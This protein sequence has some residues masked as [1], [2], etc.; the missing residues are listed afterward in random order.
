MEASITDHKFITSGLLIAAALLIR[1]FV[2]YHLNKQHFRDDDNS[3]RWINSAKNATNLII[4]MGL[5]F[6]WITELRFVALSIAT[7][8]VA[9][10]IATREFIQCFL[11][12]IYQASTRS[13]IVGDWIQLGNQCG[14]VVS[15]DWLSTRLLEIDIETCSYQTT[16]KTLFIP[17]NQFIVHPVKNLNH[18]R[19][20]IPHTISIIREADTVNVFDF[21]AA[22]LRK[23]KEYCR[24]YEGLGKHYSYP[25]NKRARQ[26]INEHEPSIRISSTA[27]GKNQFDITVYCPPHEA[28]AIEQKLTKYFMGLWYKAHKLE[29]HSPPPSDDESPQ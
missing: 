5:V 7:F 19:K 23:A 18:L 9:L 16:G 11:G 29:K 25:A 8:I 21:K 15:T 27:L 28:V 3:R 1:W 24:E 13:F 10:V 17:N 4:L 12:S 22:A 26:E 2:I 14:K 6:V 20:F